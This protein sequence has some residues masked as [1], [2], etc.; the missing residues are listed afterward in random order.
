MSADGVAGAEG[1]TVMTMNLL[2]WAWSADYDT[3]AKRKKIGKK[4][5]DIAAEFARSGD[6]EAFGNAQLDAFVAAIDETFGSDD[7]R[8]PFVV[9]RYARC[10]VINYPNAVRFELVPKVAGVGRRFGLNAAEF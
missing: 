9:E 2:L 5:G 7:S 4:F 8:R 6:H 3:P 10:V 1:L